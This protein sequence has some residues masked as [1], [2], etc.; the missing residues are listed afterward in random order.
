MRSS[1]STLAKVVVRA[2]FIITS[3]MARRSRRNLTLDR[4]S[5]SKV[6]PVRSRR[7]RAGWAARRPSSKQSYAC[8]CSGAVDI[9]HRRDTPLERRLR[10]M[11]QPRNLPTAPGE[12]PCLPSSGAGGKKPPTSRWCPH[13]FGAEAG[14]IPGGGARRTTRR[15]GRRRALRG[16]AAS[17]ASASCHGRRT[18]EGQ[19][20]PRR[21]VFVELFQGTSSMDRAGGDA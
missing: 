7:P 17:S 19:L 1:V 15:R 18:L 4:S 21:H 6:R 9:R 10:N 16:G 20:D 11:H 12:T 8:A 3:T 14:R 2:G 5:R 13:D